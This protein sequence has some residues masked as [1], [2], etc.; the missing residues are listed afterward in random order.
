MT[1]VIPITLLISH[2]IYY[3]LR[4]QKGHAQNYLGL[5]VFHT[6]VYLSSS[7]KHRQRLGK[8]TEPYLYEST[9]RQSIRHVVQP[10]CYSCRFNERPKNY[11]ISINISNQKTSA[12]FENQAS[13]MYL[14][15]ST[16]YE[17]APFLAGTGER[18]NGTV[19]RGSSPIKT[20]YFDYLK[21]FINRINEVNDFSI[22]YRYAIFYGNI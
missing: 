11:A 10:E 13:C 22:T 15:C 14:R 1:Q 8:M 2:L 5:T 16:M 20:H 17:K 4:Y 6:H 12:Q 18:K 7:L 21:L 3:A 9:L 19:A